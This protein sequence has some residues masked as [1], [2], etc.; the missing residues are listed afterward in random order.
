[1][2]SVTATTATTATPQ[3]AT[4][5]KTNALGRMRVSAARREALLD[6]FEASSA[7]APA[8]ARLAGSTTRPLPPGCRAAGGDAER[9]PTAATSPSAGQ[10]RPRQTMDYR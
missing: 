8:F 5:L 3:T 10:P 1:M 9:E 7:S 2:I 4:I 6:E